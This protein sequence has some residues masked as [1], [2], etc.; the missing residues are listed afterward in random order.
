MISKT[1][2]F[3]KE[4]KVIKSQKIYNNRDSLVVTHPTT[5]RSIYGLCMAER[6]GC[7]TFR[8]LWSYVLAT[9]ANKLYKT[10]CCTPESTSVPCKPD[11]LSSIY[12]DLLRRTKPFQNHNHATKQSRRHPVASS[13]R[14]RILQRYVGCLSGP[15]RC[16][17]IAGSGHA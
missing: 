11:F 1:N 12:T 15:S 6:T 2:S 9:L 13:D 4:G 17:A 5:N 10:N 3:A 16:R 7:P 14:L 8:S